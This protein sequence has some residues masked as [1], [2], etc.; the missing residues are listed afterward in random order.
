MRSPSPICL[1]IQLLPYPAHGIK[2][3][4]ERKVPDE[5]DHSIGAC[6]PPQQGLDLI[7]CNLARIRHGVDVETKERNP[8][9][10][11][12]SHIYDE[13]YSCLVIMQNS[14]I[15][16]LIEPEFH[17]NPQIYTEPKPAPTRTP[18]RRP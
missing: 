18:A 6:Y 1:P 11:W 12:G 15:N 17:R 7:S 8:E 16:D 10:K 14:R 4:I 9:G 2:P 3:N 13:V 5:R